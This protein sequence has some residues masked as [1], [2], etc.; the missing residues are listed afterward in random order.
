M[1]PTPSLIDRLASLS[2]QRNA[3]TD[4]LHEAVCALLSKLEPLTKTQES[5]VVGGHRLTRCRSKSNVG[6]Y[7]CWDF[8]SPVVPDEYH[9]GGD[10]HCDLDRPVDGEGYLHG[11]FN[12]AWRGPSRSELIAF[13]SRSSKF[14]EAFVAKLDCDVVVLDHSIVEVE[15]ATAAV[16]A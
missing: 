7:D 3:R 5:V 4:R 11:D 12:C 16:P 1:K 15:M 6:Y 9:D 14:V 13:A 10:K 2:A 8:S